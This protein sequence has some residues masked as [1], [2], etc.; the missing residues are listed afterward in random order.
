MIAAA[1]AGHD[2]DNRLSLLAQVPR[3]HVRR[4]RQLFWEGYH[5]PRPNTITLATKIGH[6]ARPGPQ[7]PQERH[8]HKDR[9]AHQKC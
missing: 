4:C 2:P 7:Y 9:N 6:L 8:G 1:F 5:R 3:A